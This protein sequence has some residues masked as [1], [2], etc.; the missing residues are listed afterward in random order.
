MPVDLDEIEMRQ[1]INQT[2]VRDLANA[3][4]IIGIDLVE[5]APG[6]LF[7]ADWHAV[8]HLVHPIQKMDRAEDEIEAL[9]VFLDPA[10]PR[11]GVDGIVIQF[12]ARTDF[13]VRIRC[14]QLFDFIEID[15]FVIPVV[16]GKG[17]VSE[18]TF[19]RAV[20]PRLQQRLSVR[21]DAVT[22]RMS[23]IIGEQFH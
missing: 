19:P 11:D 18:A 23:V 12:Q 4:K 21:L 14:A 5:I 9:P 2:G 22:L 20:D 8:E 17:D 13:D 3:P 10:L 16:I 15:S 1:A 7:R 6:E